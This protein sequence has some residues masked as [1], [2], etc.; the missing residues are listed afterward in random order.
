MFRCLVLLSLLVPLVAPAQSAPASGAVTRP[1]IL[2]GL[3]NGN[4]SNPEIGFTLRLDP[5]CVLTR[6][7]QAIAFSTQNPQRLSILLQCGDTRISL[8]SVPVYPDEEINLRS[9]ADASFQGMIDA[10]G[11][12]GRGTWK[13]QPRSGTE[14]LIHELSGPTGSKQ[15]ALYHAFLVGR[16]YV[17]IY[18]I[19]PE[20]NRASLSAL[21]AGLKVE[22]KTAP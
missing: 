12:K 5:G 6:E 20:Q 9:Y 21:P 13:S 15:I 19:G 4:Y 11:F 17:S 18:E 16:R 8:S 10:G 1:A 14:I 22:A 2:G 3:E 7:N